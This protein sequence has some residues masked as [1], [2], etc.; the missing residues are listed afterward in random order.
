MLDRAPTVPQCDEL[1][2]GHLSTMTSITAQTHA[3]LEH[4]SDALFPIY[5]SDAGR[6]GA[7]DLAGGPTLLTARP[8]R[9]WPQ[10]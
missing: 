5:M 9:A 7:L 2:G 1:R 8:G 3:T 4:V 10:P 6:Q